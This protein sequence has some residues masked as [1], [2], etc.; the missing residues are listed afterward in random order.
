MPRRP[1][2][3]AYATSELSQDAWI[4]WLV[5][6]LDCDERPEL[7]G[8]AR[9]FVARLWNVAR[10]G[11]AITAADVGDLREQHPLTQHER[12]DVLFEVGIRGRRVVFIVEDKTDTTHHFE[13]LAR[14]K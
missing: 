14:Y 9:D 10:P 3:L 5:A 7:R 2:I 12:I 4:C 8:A 6:N 11:D 13:Q 1:N